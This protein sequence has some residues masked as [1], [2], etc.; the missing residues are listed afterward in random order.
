VKA[1]PR[2]TD[3]LAEADARISVVCSGVGEEAWEKALEEGRA[4]ALEEA[5][6]YALEGEVAASG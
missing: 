6:S 4:M 3:F 5:V 1:V 2:H